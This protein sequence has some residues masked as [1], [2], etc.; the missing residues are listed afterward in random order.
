MGGPFYEDELQDMPSGMS[1]RAV[2]NELGT[3]MALGPETAAPFQRAVAPSGAAL[4]VSR[5]LLP[6]AQEAMRMLAERGIAVDPSQSGGLAVRNISGTDKPSKH[7]TGMAFDINW[8]DNP[9]GMTNTKMPPGMAREVATASG[10]RSGAD[11]NRPFKGPD[12]M[13]FEA[14]DSSLRGPI[15]PDGQGPFVPAPSSFMAARQPAPSQGNQ[16]NAFADIVKAALAT[17]T[18]NPTTPGLSQAP[19]KSPFAAAADNAAKQPSQSPLEAAH[20]QAQ[21]AALDYQTRQQ[22]LGRN[23]IAGLSS[24]NKRLFG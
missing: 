23:S 3:R 16:G 11:F 22:Q 17:Q 19:S 6:R 10:L 5:Q 18:P 2:L 8:K 15:A 14:P 13:H 20:A 21:Q 1:R 4:T 12:N 9:E 7:A 24:L